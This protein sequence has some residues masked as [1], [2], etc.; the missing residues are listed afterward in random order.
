MFG[1]S[2]CKSGSNPSRSQTL[3]DRFRMIPSVAQHAIWTVARTPMF[4]LQRRLELLGSVRPYLPLLTR[5][6]STPEARSRDS[7]GR[8]PSTE[9]I[10]PSTGVTPR[11]RRVCDP[12]A[13]CYVLV[14]PD[15]G[16]DVDGFVQSN[17]LIR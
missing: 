5:F 11:T 13:R 3:A 17:R 8:A 4:S 6:S 12:P 7:G 16:D 15:C 10:S 1:I 2:R 9:K 14:S